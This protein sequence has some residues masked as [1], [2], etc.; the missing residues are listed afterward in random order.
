MDDFERGWRAA[1]EALREPYPPEV[2]PPLSPD[3]VH[4]I[5]SAMNAHFPYASERMHAMWARHWADVLDRA[6]EVMPT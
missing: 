1:A 5:V 3:E 6:E 2:F 4:S